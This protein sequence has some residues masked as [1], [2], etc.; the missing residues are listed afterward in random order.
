VFEARDIALQRSVAVKAAWPRDDAPPLATEGRV[1]AAMN[2][3]S[4]P[5]VFAMSSHRDVPCM[6]ME[7]IVGATLAET[8]ELRAKLVLV[9]DAVH[10]ITAVA[11]AL[12]VVHN[13]GLVHR[14]VKPDNVMICPSGRV[15]LMDLGLGMPHFQLGTSMRLSR[16]LIEI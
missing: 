13:T 5:T 7:R 12:A 1:L 3:P 10:W 8:I 6:V 11:E 4:L 16:Y 14:D 15:V 9:C 2:H